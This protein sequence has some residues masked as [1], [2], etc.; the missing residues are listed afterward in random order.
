[1]DEKHVGERMA[2]AA[3][4]VLWLASIVLLHFFFRTESG[5]RITIPYGQYVFFA[6]TVMASA[7]LILTTWRHRWWVGPTSIP[8]ILLVLLFTVMLVSA[9]FGLVPNYGVR[10]AAILAVTTFPF[11][12][13]ASVIG[14]DQT[15]S[16]ALPVL[17]MGGVA[18]V[19]AVVLE[20]T[21]LVG[22][23]YFQLENFHYAKP[24]SWSFLFLETNGFAMYMALTVPTL[25]YVALTSTSRVVQG[26]LGVLL[27]GLL[28]VFTQ[29]TSRASLGWILLSLLLFAAAF[30]WRAVSTFRISLRQMALGVLVVSLALVLALLPFFG[31]ITDFLL[32][33]RRPDIFSGRLPM[34]STYLNSFPHDPLLGFGF[35]GSVEF[36]KQAGFKTWNLSPLNIYI[37]MLGETGLLGLGCLLLLWFGAVARVVKALPRTVMHASPTAFYLGVWLLSIL[38]GLAVHQNAEWEILRV[39][40]MHYLYVTLVVVAWRYPALTGPRA[41]LEAS[42]GERSGA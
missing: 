6:L 32:R 27:L 19:G 24:E 9:V 38:G 26:G 42:P 40:P 35:G 22:P 4:A 2:L 29:T 36:L 39:T 25:I 5:A 20:I 13:M 8:C 21:G 41:P 16:L 28:A 1:M 10:L 18:V 15:R 11:V 12:L 31:V 34:W 17:I 33:P 30:C 14:L 23:A 7:G 3:F 37:G